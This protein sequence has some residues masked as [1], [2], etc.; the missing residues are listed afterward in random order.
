MHILLPLLFLGLA[1]YSIVIAIQGK[2][3]AQEDDSALNSLRKKYDLIRNENLFEVDYF[4]RWFNAPKPKH[5]YAHSGIFGR[6][7]KLSGQHF[8]DYV[9]SFGLQP[10]EAQAFY[11]ENH[12]QFTKFQD[13]V[14]DN[15]INEAN[16][17]PNTVEDEV[18][19]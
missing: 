19:G 13:A 7:D 10:L 4:N 16:I 9:A 6:T 14:R 2:N 5:I 15:W 8:V 12:K 11:D 17:K 18:Q 3:K 1:I